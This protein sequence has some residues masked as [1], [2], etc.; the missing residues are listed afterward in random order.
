[1]QFHE[2][3]GQVDLPGHFKEN[4]YIYRESSIIKHPFSK[5]VYSERKLF[6]HWALTGK[7]LHYRILLFRVQVVEHSSTVQLCCQIVIYNSY[8]NLRRMT[9]FPRE[10]IQ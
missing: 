10:I 6:A 1:M 3:F 7:N 9:A 4:G 5:G 8:E 2:L